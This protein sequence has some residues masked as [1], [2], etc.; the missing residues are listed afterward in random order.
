LSINKDILGKIVKIT[1]EEIKKVYNKKM[2][3]RRRKSK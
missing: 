2:Y 1:C 3:K